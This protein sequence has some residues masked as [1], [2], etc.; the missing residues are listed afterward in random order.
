MRESRL[1]KDRQV[2][3][4]SFRQ[5]SCTK[6]P[7]PL[8]AHGVFFLQPQR[9]QGGGSGS[10]EIPPGSPLT[11]ALDQKSQPILRFS[12]STSRSP[13]Y[14]SYL[15]E[16]LPLVDATGDLSAVE[17]SVL[18]S[19]RI[20]LPLMWVWE[21]HPCPRPMLAR[22]IN[23]DKRYNPGCAR[24]KETSKSRNP[25]SL[26]PWRWLALLEVDMLH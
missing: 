4:R 16:S 9:C 14:D 5:M 17:F 23:S 26:R 10:A 18:L 24:T 7:I 21:H 22:R 20:V 1:A 6:K 2:L 8:G 11:L 25:V 13:R 15:L 3:G 12:I 19:P